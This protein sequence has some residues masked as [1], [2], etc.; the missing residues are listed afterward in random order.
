MAKKRMVDTRFWH[1]SWVRKLNALD[2]YLF[3]YLMTNDKCTFCGIYELPT[4]NMA[5]DT[6]I[7]ERDLEHTMLPRLAPKVH[8]YQG[9]VYLVNF[10]KHH[11]HEGSQNSLKGY[12]AA[13][14]EVPS[15]ILEY[16]EKI[17]KP[18]EAP[19]SPSDT[20]ASASAF[21]SAIAS[22][23][24]SKN[25]APKNSYGEFANVL[26]TSDEYL[27]ICEALGDENAN[28]LIAELS[29]YVASSGKR[30]KNHYATLLTW[31]RRRIQ[32]HRLKITKPKA[33][34]AFT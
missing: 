1:D 32:E 22:T 31:A 26:L 21:A 6:G 19:P 10:K 11:V 34:I 27:R 14:S 3:L 12:E 2:R 30:Y 20:I 8:Y 9:W 28:G 24:A 33:K 25:E 5:F 17:D 15:H 4:T 18:L 23:S 7:D 16:F 29:S 13:L